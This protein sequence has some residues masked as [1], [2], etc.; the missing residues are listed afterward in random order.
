VD[1]TNPATEWNGVL[2]FDES[3]NVV[4]PKNGWV[5]NTN[6]FPFS[7]AGP[8]NSPNQ[9]DFPAYVD[10]G[11]E[12]PRGIHAIKVLT[13]K[14]G[15]TL[16]G[17]IKDVAYSSFQ[18][19]FEIQIPLLLKAHAAAPASNPLKAKTAPAIE[20]LKGWDYRWGAASVQQSVAIFYGDDLWTRVQ[21]D[22]RKAR[23]SVYEYMRTRATPQQ[24]LE[25]LAA[26]MDKLTA[27]FGKWQTPWGDINRFQR[28]DG[29]IVQT[30]DDSKPSTPVHFA[31]A[32]WGSLASYGARAYPQTKKWYGTSGNSF[33]A[34]VEFG[35]RVKAKAVTAGGLNSVPSRDSR[36]LAAWGLGLGAWG[37]AS[38][39]SAQSMDEVS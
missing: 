32:R 35:D 18:P 16:D 12:N 26:A 17:L 4:N 34:V 15:L 1:G 22:A 25:S 19:E 38:V 37:L 8:G 31:S 36:D 6:N 23:L 29:S 3:P 7:A 33:V 30:F 5:M 27:D 9:K 20:V 21:A 14:K 39:L 11:S 2:S 10:S 28:N 24:R 13:G